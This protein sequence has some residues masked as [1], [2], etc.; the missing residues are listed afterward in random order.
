MSF[1]AFGT[2]ALAVICRGG[3]FEWL[4]WKEISIVAGQVFLASVERCE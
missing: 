3:K 2:G 1:V 4:T